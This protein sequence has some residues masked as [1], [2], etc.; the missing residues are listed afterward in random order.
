MKPTNDTEKKMMASFPFNNLL[1]FF[2]WRL[3]TAREEKKKKTIQVPLQCSFKYQTINNNVQCEIVVK[4]IWECVDLSIL[5]FKR[6]YHVVSIGP[7]VSWKR[8]RERMKIMFNVFFFYRFE[9][10]ILNGGKH[11]NHLTYVLSSEW[12]LIALTHSCVFYASLLKV[13]YKCDRMY[14]RS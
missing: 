10:V 9:C 4:Y 11:E 8:R 7:L 5:S 6:S 2:R 14:A 1:V 13:L 12:K 3:Q